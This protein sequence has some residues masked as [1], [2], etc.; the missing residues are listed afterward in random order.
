MP[1][2]KLKYFIRIDDDV[3]D[4]ISNNHIKWVDA[5]PND[6]L[7]R[8][9]LREE[10]I[11]KGISNTE[12]I[13][14]RYLP[15]MCDNQDLIILLQIV[16]RVLIFKIPRK[17]AINLSLHDN[18]Y[19][20]YKIRKLINDFLELSMKEFDE[21]LEGDINKLQYMIIK[22]FPKYDRL[23]ERFFSSLSKKMQKQN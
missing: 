6:V 12:K 17:T 14:T 21:Y 2:R 10:A 23:I 20:D 18:S 7:R 5:T 19:S 1:N 22:Q 13:R 8:K 11:E 3:M 16:E 15:F 4:Y 9:L